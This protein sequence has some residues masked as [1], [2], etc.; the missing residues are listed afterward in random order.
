MSSDSDAPY[1]IHRSNQD[2]T[3]DAICTRCFR[4]VTTQSGRDE[5]AGFEDSHRCTDEGRL[6]ALER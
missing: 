3:F 2:G 5:L 6:G 1:F 4:T